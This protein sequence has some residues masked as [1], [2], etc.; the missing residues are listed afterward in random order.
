MVGRIAK[1]GRGMVGR[2]AK[3]GGGRLEEEYR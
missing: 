2:I 1:K 3:K